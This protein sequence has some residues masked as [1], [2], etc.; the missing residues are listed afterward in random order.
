MGDGRAKEPRP[1]TKECNRIRLE[2]KHGTCESILVLDVGRGPSGLKTDGVR[3]HYR[4]VLYSHEV[5][6]NP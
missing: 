1:G 5:E 4:F 6:R 3:T 2:T